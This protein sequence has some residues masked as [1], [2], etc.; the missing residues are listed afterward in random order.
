M[1]D[2]VRP[3][4][5][6]DIAI[7]ICTTCYRRVDAKIVFEDGR[8][9]ML[10]H[11]PEHGDER[12]LLADDVEYYRRC[13]EVF[14]KTPE[15][16]AR[17][18]TPVKWGCPYDCGLCTDHQ[19]HSC[20]TL[21][22]ICDYCNLRCPVCYAASGPDRQQFRSLARIEGMLDAVVRN[23]G[24]PDVVQISGGE[25]TEHPDFFTVLDLAK[26]R[27]I[28][29]V[30]VN[31]NG[32]RIAESEAFAERLA[33]YMPDFEVYLQFD[34]L[35]REP[36]LQLR[37][38]D[39]RAVRK[40]AIERLNR[41]GIST[42]LVVTLKKGLNDGEIGGII[43]YALEQPCV[44]GVTLQPI[45]AAGRLHGFDPATDRLTLTEVRRR[46]LEQSAVF[47]PEDIIPVPCHPDALAMAYAL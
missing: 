36:L 15:M 16:P 5:F 18:N 24:R 28:R 9:L 30:M 11:C 41:H 26:A 42:T 7:S 10:K 32:V 34:S 27:P 44:R 46:I 35:E 19:Q 6:Y 43:D 40:R 31:T 4:L 29:H 1:T 21:V 38:V 2:R 37:G 39:L 45:Q 14:L 20:L 3:Y 13:R 22:E 47:R 12:V 17:F 25:P 8:V 33:G 23:E